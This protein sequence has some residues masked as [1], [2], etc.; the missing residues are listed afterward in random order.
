MKT[1]KRPGI[2]SLLSLADIVG[3]EPWIAGGRSASRNALRND[4]ETY[5]G[6]YR[7]SWSLI[8]DSKHF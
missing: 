6:Y 1:G 4:P 7:Y 5:A 3:C 8:D 2:L